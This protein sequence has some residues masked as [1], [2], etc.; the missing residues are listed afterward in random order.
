[1]EQTFLEE[2]KNVFNRALERKLNVLAEGFCE[3]YSQYTEQVGG[4]KTIK[5]LQAEFDS[6]L[7]AYFPNGLSNF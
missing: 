1:M 6:L 2:V 4:L 5:E 7:Q 3:E